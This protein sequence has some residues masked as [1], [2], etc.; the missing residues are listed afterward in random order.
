MITKK[1]FCMQWIKDNHDDMYF[2][3][4]DEKDHYQ[5]G[6]AFFF[7][8]STAK[9]TVPKLHRVFQADAAHTAFGKYTLFSLYG[10]TANGNMYPVALGYVFGNENKA[11]WMSFWEFVVKIH[12]S[13]NEPECTIITDQLA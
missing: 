10:T 3:L 9:E 1:D 6:H 2:P 13:L 5:F 12:P 7:S 4:G 8:P 11:A